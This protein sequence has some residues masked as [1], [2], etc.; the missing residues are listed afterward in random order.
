MSDNTWFINCAAIYKESDDTIAI[1]MQNSNNQDKF[2]KISN[3]IVISA[4]F[5]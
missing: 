3:S 2:Q 1:I 5:T 4:L